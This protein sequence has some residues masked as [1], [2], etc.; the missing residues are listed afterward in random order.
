VDAFSASGP[1]A[2]RSMLYVDAATPSEVHR[3][4]NRFWAEPPAR[5]L[6]DIVASYLA[7][8]RAADI[9]VTPEQRLTPDHIVSGH[10]RVFEEGLGEGAPRAIVE[11]DLGLVHGSARSRVTL[12]RYREESPLRPA[13]ARTDPVVAAFERAVGEVCRRFVADLTEADRRAKGGAPM[14][15]SVRG[16]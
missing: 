15:K 6:R 10:L 11:V 13:G 4:T 14:R 1:V 2:T 12:K 5:M 7:Q 8:V 3:R 9:V 16:R